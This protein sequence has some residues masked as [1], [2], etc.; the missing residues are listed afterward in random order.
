[1]WYRQRQRKKRG[2]VPEE[3]KEKSELAKLMHEKL[4]L[5]IK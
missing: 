3:E 2:I 4:M 1:M 5:T